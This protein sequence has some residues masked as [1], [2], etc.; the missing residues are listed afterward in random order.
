[1]I[2]QNTQAI[3]KTGR[4][5][6]FNP[7]HHLIIVIIPINEQRMNYGIEIPNGYSFV[8]NDAIL[9][10]NNIENNALVNYLI[11][12]RKVLVDE[13]IKVDDNT[14]VYPYPGKIAK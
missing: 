3:I 9:K 12:D 8:G 10:Y 13:Y 11:N 14:P 5:K 1:M 2:Y 4:K 7:Q 6:L